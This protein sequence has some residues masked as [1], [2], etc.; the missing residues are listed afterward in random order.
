MLRHNKNTSDFNPITKKNCIDPLP[1]SYKEGTPKLSAW[2][3]M[4]RA[5]DRGVTNWS[6]Q[7]EKKVHRACFLVSIKIMVQSKV[8]FGE[9]MR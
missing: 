3:K 5:R 4:S 1:V 9:N 8:Q 2:N 7:E 6:P